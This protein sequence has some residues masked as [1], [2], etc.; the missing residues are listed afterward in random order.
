MRQEE[1]RDEQT[2]ALMKVYPRLLSKHQADVG[3]MSALLMVPSQMNLGLYLDMRMTSVSFRDQRTEHIADKQ[4]YDSLWDDITKQ[5]LQHTD[6]TV[7]TAAIQ[8]I[9][10]LTLNTSLAQNNTTKLN[11]L[12]E[13]LF[14]S[15]RDAINGQDVSSMSIDDEEVASIEA[16]LFRLTLL[17][18][19][20]D[21]TEVME[22]EEGGQSSGWEIVCAFAERGELPYK[23]EAKVSSS[24]S[25][26]A[27]AHS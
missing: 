27:S 21:I 5:F 3:R 14:T 23:D 10:E 4:A 25:R 19:S 8:A 11:E 17:A 24:S 18:K 1:N 12:T 9:N 15:L 6:R 22:D 7:L 16:I 13:S 26:T 2:K 20:R